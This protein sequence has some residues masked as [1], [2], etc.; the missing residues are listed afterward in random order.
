MQRKRIVCGLMWMKCWVDW[1]LCYY[2]RTFTP[3]GPKHGSIYKTTKISSIF[4]CLKMRGTSRWNVMRTTWYCILCTKICFKLGWKMNCQEK[5]MPHNLF[6]IHNNRKNNKQITIIGVKEVAKC[7]V[8]AFT[9]ELRVRKPVQSK[10]KTRKTLGRL[11]A[12]AFQTIVC[13]KWK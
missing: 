13:F 9:C 10:N 3:F 4:L 1:V 7:L 6:R 5:Q 8:L 12:L 2:Y 11:N